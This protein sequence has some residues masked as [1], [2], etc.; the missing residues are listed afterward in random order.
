MDPDAGLALA[1]HLSREIPD[2]SV[3]LQSEEE[4]NERRAREVGVPFL[5]KNSED[6]LLD[7]RAFIL[8]TY[9]F[10]E[11]VFRYPDRTEIARA[12]AIEEFEE[13]IR[14]LPAESMIYHSSRNDFSKWF[15][16]RTEFEIADE[17]RAK[18]TKATDDPEI[19]RKY[20]LDA[21]A[22][23]Y[24]RY[25]FGVIL[26][27]G[28]ARLDMDNSMT[29]LGE[30]SLGGKARG[31][32]FFNALLNQSGINTKYPE[33]TVK[34]PRS[35][36]VGS[37]VFEHFMEDNRLYDT[38]IHTE[39]EETIT[40]AFLAAELPEKIIRHLRVL[41]EHADYPL[42]VRS[43]SILEDSQVLPF[44]GIYKTFILPNN[45]PDPEA[46]LA[47]IQDAIKLIYASVFY[48][49]PRQY[50]RNADL[51]I[52]EER[53]AVLIQRLVGEPHGARFYPA[54]SGVAQSYNCYPYSHMKPEDG[55]ACLALGFGK[56]VVEGG[57]AYRF[58][59]AHP[60]LNPPSSSVGEFIRQTQNEF[61]ALDLT[62]NSGSLGADESRA[63]RKLALAAAQD[64][65]VLVHIASTYSPQ[66]DCLYDSAHHPG[67][68]VVTFAGILKHDALPLAPVV[69]DLLEMG[70]MAFGSEVEIE[71]AVNIPTD[72]S[73]Q[74]EFFFLQIRP[75]VVGREAID[76]RLESY[77]ADA[78]LCRS[79]HT[80]GNGVFHD[81]RDIIY[82]EPDIYRQTDSALVAEEIGEL[83][84]ILYDEGRRCILIGFGRMGTADP[85][86]GIPVAW[87]HIS[88]AKVVI[89]ADRESLQV[90][91]SLGS[92][93]YHNLSSLR[94]GYLHVGWPSSAEEGIDWQAL[95]GVEVIA[96]TRHVRL[97]R[98]AEP[99][100]VIIDGRNN[101][102]IVLKP[103]AAG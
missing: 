31:I 21:L 102:G 57:N 67:P 54:I 64:D 18:S 62:A 16:A 89:E 27:F 1:A 17:L 63:Y 55:V 80:I 23:F 103:A 58:S 87:R 11:F 65:G 32:A 45:Q 81:L 92:H 8:E 71:F 76:I 15:R 7:L 70:R 88:Q 12:A 30:G 41:L 49:S 73:Q 28:L 24:K 94:M 84:R 93:F 14:T 68:K 82:V 38:A 101:R 5:N 22:R 83:N 78:A 52:E 2:L 56:T 96:R 99:L 53:M 48:Q 85:W 29:R 98:S 69:R 37:E 36:V 25:Q 40:R 10:G 75:M 59:P 26:D 72:L 33:M 86:L 34:T 90:E 4:R 42:A 6:L 44:A 97:A 50:A 51:R 46:R 13:V 95:R 20:V 61:Y 3:L 9:G 91:P 47:Q 66:D 60:A 100:H 43:S 77:P 19:A 39:D 79:A 35:F 74:V